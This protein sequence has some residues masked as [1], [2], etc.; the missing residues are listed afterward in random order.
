MKQRIT[1]LFANSVLALGLFGSAT[2][3]SLEDSRSAYQR[4]EYATAMR[5]SRPLAE[6]GNAE[7]QTALGD[8]YVNGEG[9]PQ[10]FAEAVAW[11]RKAA[12]QGHAF[13]QGD[14]GLMYAEGE[15]VPQDFVQAH[16]WLTLAVEHSGDD[17]FAHDAAVKYRDFIAAEMTPYQI[18]DALRLAREWKPTK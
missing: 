3:G 13:A 14:L 8:M 10:D 1:T 6:C 4:G 9:V 2:A 15:G 5:L 16:L 11:Y 12:K 17:K 7:A 18:A